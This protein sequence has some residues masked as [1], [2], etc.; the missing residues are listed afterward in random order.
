[1]LEVA[2]KMCPTLQVIIEQLNKMSTNQDEIRNDMTKI[3]GE[4]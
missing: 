1:M 2:R 3:S 4:E